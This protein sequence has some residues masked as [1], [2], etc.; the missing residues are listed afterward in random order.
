[1]RE[2]GRNVRLPQKNN[3]RM[4][5]KIIAPFKDGMLALPNGKKIEVKN[6]AFEVSFEEYK[7]YLFNDA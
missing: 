4:S 2:A 6:S 5:V 7:Q 1:M 3:R